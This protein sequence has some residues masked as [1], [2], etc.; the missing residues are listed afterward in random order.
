MRMAFGWRRRQVVG[1]CKQ[2]KTDVDSYNEN[3]THND[4]Y[5]LVLNF[6]NDVADSEQD[7]EYN[8]PPPPADDGDEGDD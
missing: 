2:L 4:F 8:P 7:T 3:N 5:Q 6:E 1:D